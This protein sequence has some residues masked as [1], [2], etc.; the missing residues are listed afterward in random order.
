M[1]KMT[2]SEPF[3]YAER[4]SIKN[5]IAFKRLRR[6]KK[7][8]QVLRVTAILVVRKGIEMPIVGT[9]M[10]MQAKDQQNRKIK[11]KVEEGE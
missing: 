6:V 7:A 10:K 4:K 5:K 11:T 2:S 8:K 3:M 9:K 1:W